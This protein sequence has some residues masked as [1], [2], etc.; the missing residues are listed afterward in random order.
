L[1]IKE[2]LTGE[3]HAALAALVPGAFCTF[4][5]LKLIVHEDPKPLCKVDR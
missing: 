4:H 2:K 5:E 3:I 1:V